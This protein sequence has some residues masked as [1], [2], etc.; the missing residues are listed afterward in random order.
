MTSTLQLTATVTPSPKNGSR[1]TAGLLLIPFTMLLA[2][3]LAA[4]GGEA[5][6]PASESAPAPA[7]KP[8][9]ATPV[10]E[11]PWAPAP[12]REELADP[13]MTEVS[14]ITSDDVKI[15]A[16]YHYLPRRTALPG[17]VLVHQLGANRS[18]WDSIV[19]VL[20]DEGFAVLVIDL[21]GHG[22]ST[23][24][25]SLES[26]QELDYRKFDAADWGDLVLDVAAAIEY[27]AG[28]GAVD[29]ERIVLFGS[30]IG[31][32]AAVRV[33]SGRPSIRAGV[34]FSPGSSYRGVD[35]AA[36]VVLHPEQAV[37]A[38]AGSGD[39]QS[40]GFIPEIEAV[41]SAG[42]TYFEVLDSSTHGTGLFPEFS[43]SGLRD[44]LLEFLRRNV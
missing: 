9:A 24:R 13:R 16:D 34:F 43:G 35:I 19:P 7:A 11:E 36:D 1:P 44:A 29:P 42:D 14:F 8:A 2:L 30:S 38:I 17:A 40:A 21:R 39:G 26:S 20:V 18:D 23:R 28:T 31:S 6:A 22:A 12:S 41:T 27:L 37:F 15:F 5:V 25:G 3:V 32:S 33:M 10:S 4:C